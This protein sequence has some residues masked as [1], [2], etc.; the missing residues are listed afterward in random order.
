MTVGDNKGMRFCAV[1]MLLVPCAWGADAAIVEQIVAKVNGDII[2]RSEIDRARRTFET[3]MRTRGATPQQIQDALAQ[4]EKDALRDRIDQL[5]LVQRAKDLNINVD[6]EV[7]KY[8]GSI[9]QQQK[10]ADPEKFQAWVKEQSGMSFEDFRSEAKNSMMTER[11]I[12]QEVGG[13]IQISKDDV[14]K[15]YD[16]HK[17]DFMRE[18][19]VFLREIVISIQGKDAAGVAAAEKKAKDLVARAKKGEKFP[20]LARD[21]SESDSARQGGELGAFKKGDLRED[22]VKLLWEKNKG[23]VTDPILNPGSSYVIFRVE[24]HHK[25]GQATLPEVENEVREKLYMPQFQPKVRE[26]LTGLRESAFLEIRE[27]FLDSGAAPG[28]DTHW[29][30]PALLKPA[31]VTKEE[32]ANQ[33]HRK[34]VLGV[35]I[36]GTHSTAPGKSSSK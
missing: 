4:K 36:P 19:Q 17:A 23:Y 24:D 20:D 25:A 3:E 6:N 32:V 13:K 7:S 28:K 9:Q 26:Y 12:G 34:K 16:E 35:P 10:I 1:A 2:T 14:Q 33:S 27:G 15:Y 11:V 5:L 31:T 18:E 8:L 21:N 29:N 30:D 22:L